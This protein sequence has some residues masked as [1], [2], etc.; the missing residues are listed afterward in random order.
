MTDLDW[1]VDDFTGVGYYRIWYQRV[2]PPAGPFETISEMARA[3]DLRD[4]PDDGMIVHVFN[5]HPSGII[6]IGSVPSLNPDD[7]VSA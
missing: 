1:N 3:T 4:Y 6:E 7:L 2:N 5:I